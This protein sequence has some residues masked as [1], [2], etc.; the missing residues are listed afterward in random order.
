MAEKRDYYEVLGVAKTATADEIKKA[1]KKMAL[2]YHP[3]RHINDSEADKKAADKKANAEAK[4]Q[5]KL[6]AMTAEQKEA[7]AKKA[8]IAKAKQE[9]RDA[10]ALVELNKIREE[11]QRGPVTL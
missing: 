11:N 6:D 1:Y 5:A 2:Q 10:K 7:A 8:E 4:K 9:E 3:D